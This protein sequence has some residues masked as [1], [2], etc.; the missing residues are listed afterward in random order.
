M[1]KM[2]KFLFF[3]SIGIFVLLGFFVIPEHPHFIWEKIPGFDALFGFIGCIIIVVV[4]KALG[5]HWLQKNE[6]YYD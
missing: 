2:L 5:H 1:L 4:S 3:I 6:D